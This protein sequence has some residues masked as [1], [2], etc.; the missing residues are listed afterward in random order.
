MSFESQVGK[1]AVMAEQHYSVIDCD[2]HITESIA[3]LAE[4]MDPA[5]RQFALHPPR[6]RTGVFPSMTGFPEGASRE[7]RDPQDESELASVHRKGSGEDWLGFLDKAG[8][9]QAVVFPSDALS[10]GF[11]QSDDY[12]DRVCRA[13]ND[14]VADRYARVSSRIRPAA[15]LPMQRV[16][17]AVEELRRAVKELGLI[18]G[19]L[20]SKGLPLHLA[21]EYYWPL[22]EE[23]ADL[24]CPLC[25]HGG[26]HLGTGMDSFTVSRATSGL[27]HSVPLEI[28]LSAFVY[29]G[30]LDRF[31]S[32]R[33]AF[34]EGGCAWVVVLADVE[35]GGDGVRAT[36]QRRLSDYAAAGRI[37]VGVDGNPPSLAYAASRIGVEGLAWASDYPHGSD[38]DVLPTRRVLQATADRSDLSADDKRAVLSENARRF[39]KLPVL[40]ATDPSSVP[41]VVA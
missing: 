25:V 1:V 17:S 41:A 11:I 23:A 3:E 37:L 15:L 38:R 5:M 19:M 10:V 4:F 31:P 28:A 27:R 14:Y 22:Y 36:G 9:E 7:P 26:T 33:V 40:A 18:G 13:Y 24:D 20:P 2:G 8:V 6:T 30:V 34:L 21:H 32:L 29:H 16:S 12:A 35:A 39:Y